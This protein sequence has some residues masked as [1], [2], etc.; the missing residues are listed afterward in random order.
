VPFAVAFPGLNNPFGVHEGEPAVFVLAAFSFDT[1]P[2]LMSPPKGQARG[3]IA[4]F[5]PVTADDG[6]T[7][8]AEAMDSIPEPQSAGD[9]R[10]A[11][12]VP[13]GISEGWRMPK[14][15]QARTA[16][17]NWLREG[18][19][20]VELMHTEEATAVLDANTGETVGNP[21]EPMPDKIGD[22]VWDDAMLGGELASAM[23]SHMHEPAVVDGETTGTDLANR[24]KLWRRTAAAVNKRL[25]EA[26]SPYQPD[27]TGRIGPALRAFLD[28][29]LKLPPESGGVDEIA[30]AIQAD[31]DS[32]AERENIAEAEQAMREGGLE[33]PEW[34]PGVKPAKKDKKDKKPS[35]ARRRRKF[36]HTHTDD[37]LKVKDSIGR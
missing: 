33:L 19:S 37:F 29:R 36:D 12:F 7:M 16:T 32:A 35:V 9:G 20:A 17:G 2:P 8:L 26:G 15:E 23:F 31:R 25:A 4:V 18:Q 1:T 11:R 22:A 30:A 10:K 5:Q 3:R 34:M 14:E 24:F 13:V 6:L 21:D 28:K 27:Y